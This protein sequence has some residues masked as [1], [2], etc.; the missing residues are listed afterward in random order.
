HSIYVGTLSLPFLLMPLD[1]FI[2]F[3]C[4]KSLKHFTM[5][6]HS[7]C[8]FPHRLCAEDSSPAFFMISF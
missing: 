3:I 5:E 6:T 2:P 4:L 8:N 1:V 7:A